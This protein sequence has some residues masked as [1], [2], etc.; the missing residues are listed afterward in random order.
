MKDK[1]KAAAF[2]VA[3][4]LVLAAACAAG[5]LLPDIQVPLVAAGFAGYVLCGR[6]AMALLRVDDEVFTRRSAARS[7]RTSSAV[8]AG[9]MF[10]TIAS[11]T[12]GQA[13]RPE[14][15]PSRRGSPGPPRSESSPLRFPQS[16]DPKPSEKSE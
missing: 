8:A 16:A 14:A 1:R 15:E 13:A 9:L 4:V 11:F 10:G 6:Q 2:A 7:P 5:L 12:L 3:S